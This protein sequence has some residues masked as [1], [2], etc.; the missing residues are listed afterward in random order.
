[1]PDQ[2]AL[3]RLVGIQQGQQRDYVYWSVKRDETPDYAGQ[4]RNTAF[5]HAASFARMLI[6]AFCSRT[7]DI[8]LSNNKANIQAV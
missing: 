2:E 7:M 8:L 3:K 1:M 6:H 5:C 4:C